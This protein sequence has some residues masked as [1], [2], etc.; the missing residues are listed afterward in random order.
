MAERGSDPPD[1][2][3]F[4]LRPDL[5]R[6]LLRRLLRWYSLEESW[7]SRGASGRHV[8]TRVPSRA[9]ADAGR[10]ARAALSAPHAGRLLSVVCDAWEI[11]VPELAR[12]SGVPEVAVSGFV[13]GGS[14]LGNGE[15][16]RLIESLDGMTA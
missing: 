1:L 11:P 12:R 8:G 6:F 7:R 13:S 3:R 10:L 9:E 5:E 4:L 2:E 14:G 16:R 15:V